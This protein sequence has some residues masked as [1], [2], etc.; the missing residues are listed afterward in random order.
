[1]N[2]R[3]VAY[4]PGMPLTGL[5]TRARTEMCEVEVV[6]R[7]LTR[8]DCGAWTRAA[9]ECSVA[10]NPLDV[11]DALSNLAAASVIHLT[12]ERVVLSRTARDLICHCN[13]RCYQWTRR[14]G[15]ISPGAGSPLRRD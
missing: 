13:L 5:S 7:L 8:D 14:V 10:G 6:K 11:S 1:M 12:E 4:P 9:L 3:H 15:R 2:S